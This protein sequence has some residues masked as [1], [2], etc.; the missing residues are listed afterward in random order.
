MANITFWKSNWNEFD[1]TQNG[2]DI[3]DQQITP[4]VSGDLIPPVR[5]FTAEV[6][7]ER[8][9]KFFIKTDADIITTSLEMPMPTTCPTEDVFYGLETKGDHTDVESDLDKDNFR[10]YGSFFV[11]SVDADNRKVVADRNVEAFIKADDR[12][13]FWNLTTGERKTSMEVESVSGSEITFKEWDDNGDVAGGDG[14]CSILPLP[15]LNADEYIGIWLKEVI[16]PFTKPM[17]D[18]QNQII[19]SVVYDD[20]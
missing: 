10:L 1:P 4:G 20:K 9:V 12:V 18:P 16:Q 5:P 2:G 7:G 13:S 17:E 11:S 6:G 3:T 19:F 15:D 14:G 8:W